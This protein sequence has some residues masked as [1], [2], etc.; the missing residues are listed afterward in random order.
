MLIA[1]DNRV[2]NDTFLFTKLIVVGRFI[3]E[4]YANIYNNSK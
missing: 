3:D 2:S 1:S 4:I